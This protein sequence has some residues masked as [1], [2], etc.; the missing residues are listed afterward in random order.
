MTQQEAQLKVN[1]LLEVHRS[2]ATTH[3]GRLRFAYSVT[4][5]CGDVAE[6]AKDGGRNRSQLFPALSESGVLVLS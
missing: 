4:L 6:C 3:I 1:G 5:A 2:R